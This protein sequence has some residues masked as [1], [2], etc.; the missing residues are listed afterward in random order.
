L[1]TVC[2]WY[3]YMVPANVGDFLYDLVTH[4]KQNKISAADTTCNLTIT[5]EANRLNA[6]GSHTVARGLLQSEQIYDNA[7]DSYETAV[8]LY[9]FIYDCEYES[10][11]DEFV[12]GCQQTPPS[13]PPEGHALNFKGFPYN[14][15]A[16]YNR[17]SEI[18]IDEWRDQSTKI[19]ATNMFDEGIRE[20]SNLL[21]RQ[22]L[23]WRTLRVGCSVQ[24]CG[25][26]IIASVACVYE[27]PA[28]SPGD[29]MYEVGKPCSAD[30]ECTAYEPAK[31]DVDGMLCILDTISSIT[32]S[33]STS[34]TSTTV[35]NTT[36]ST[37]SLA[38]TNANPNT[39]T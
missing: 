26:G 12:Q 3:V 25:G 20:L 19:K 15:G 36:L 7:G 37:S 33:T 1:S 13:T 29:Q 21:L 23:N 27:K 9:D 38:T 5:S 35:L 8:N 32:S 18:A 10:I 4:K 24:S 34:T 30:E 31:C 14:G 11:A 2:L 17:P 16:T 6:L 28:L 22:M 39:G